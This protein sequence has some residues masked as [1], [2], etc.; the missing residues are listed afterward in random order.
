MK[1]IIFF[2]CLLF[3]LNSCSNAFNN[4]SNNY[5]NSNTSG[6]SYDDIKERKIAWN[7]I[8]KCAKSQ[9]FVYF[10]MENCLHCNEIKQYIISLAIEEKVDIFFVEK[11]DEI[12]I[13][14]YIEN[15]IGESL[16]D[17]I[18][19]AGYPSIILFNEGVVKDNVLGKN[20]IL[21]LLSKYV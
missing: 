8:N 13:G 1:K 19:I 10:Y 18:F 7:M 9:Y 4:N 17:Y 2:I 11:N 14:K 15:T 16:L 6:Y 3:T 21:N 5:N 12:V 20:D